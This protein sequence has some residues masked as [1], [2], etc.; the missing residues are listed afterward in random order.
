ML[1][2]TAKRHGK[3]RRKP[4]VR[5]RLWR[6]LVLSPPINLAKLIFNVTLFEISALLVNPKGEQI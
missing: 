4:Q 2:K 1:A 5:L 6:I 3:N